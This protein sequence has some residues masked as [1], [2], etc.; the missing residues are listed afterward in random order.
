[1][2]ETT[3]RPPASFP[4]RTVTRRAAVRGVA[5][6]GLTTALGGA[7][8]FDQDRASAQSDAA[9][10]AAT[11]DLPATASARAR[12]SEATLRGIEADVEAAM[13]TFRVPGAAVALVQG[14]EIVFNRGFGV[15]NL[16]SGEPVT[17]RTRFRI[18]SITK[19][20]TTLTL[21]T[22]VDEGVFGW[23]DH[24]VDVWT[25]F[26]APTEGLMQT[27]R[28]RD[29][30]GMAS[31]IAESTELSVAAVE[32]FMSAG[33]VSAGDVLRSIAELPVIAV[34]NT[35]YSYNNTLYAVAAFVGLLAAGTPPEAL[36]EAYMAEV[37]RRVFDP[38]AMTDAAILDDPRPLG[39]DY[40]IG[41]ARNLF[42]DPSPL[43]FVSLA[44]IA[45]AGSGLA[46][47]TDMA[48]YLITQMHEGVAPGG[49]RVVSAANL[50]ETHRPGILVEPAALFPPEVQSD[51]VALHYGMGWLSETYR[52]GRRLL[53]HSGGIDGFSSL[54]GFFPEAQLGFVF[55]TNAGRGG[56]LFN[57]S[58]Q[59]SLLDRQ[60][61]LNRE[62]PAFLAG[63][64]PML[65]A[66]TA[67]LAAQTA[68]VDPA[69]VAPYLGQYEDG[70]QVRLDDAGTLS[71]DHDIRSMPLLALPDGTYVIAD[72][73]DVVLE[74]PVTFNRDSDGLPIMT[75]QGFTPVRWLTGG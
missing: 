10:P 75:I 34:P 73:P 56:G 41:Y 42:G 35:T 45:P 6:T 49:A 32:F 55:L 54:M 67:E 2:D 48:R 51:T 11:P 27:L 57:L 68:P 24:V 16:E 17:P 5:A 60:F 64:V 7:A 44:G 31:G 72:G 15:R 36:E 66:R 50:A 26:R 21:A 14:S 12:L 1:M 63:F 28:L 53:W 29:L 13:R 8:G 22:L 19:S 9:T 33:T 61:G 37:R 40:A 30:L 47:A 59:A 69:A 20:L 74:Q 3:S 46:S 65:E 52:D 71:L 62:L 43:P 23:D 4:A 38:I 25:E 18:G 70:F 58:V 39:D